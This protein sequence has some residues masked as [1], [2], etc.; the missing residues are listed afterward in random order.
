MAYEDFD[1]GAE[2]AAAGGK[3]FKNPEPGPH[4]SIVTAIVHVGSFADVFTNGAKK[5]PK[6]AVN[7]V[8][9]QTTLMGEE[10]KNDDGSRIQKWQ[11]MPLKKGDKANLTKFLAAVDP[12]GK[13]AG[14][15]AVPGTPVVTTWAANEKKGKNDDG[16]WK[17]VNL[18][19]YTAVTGRTGALIKAD[20]EEE[21]VPMI[22]HVRFSDLTL[23]IL[24][25]IPGYM[26][27]QYLLSESEGN[28]ES[29]AGS[30]V[31]AIINAKRAEDASWKTKQEGDDE[32]DHNEPG[33]EQKSGST[34]GASSVPSEPAAQDVPPPS[35]LNE[36]KEF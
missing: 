13:L 7:F 17:A 3:V 30:P 14:F 8:L 11:A 20:F 15:D 26:I 31:E 10:D 1:F 24:E 23:E 35:D 9:V 25:E 4:D 18:K 5:E 36:D 12:N 34:A 28:N 29:Y 33:N 19:G 32:G 22:G 21:A 27:R 2:V 6:P 16:T